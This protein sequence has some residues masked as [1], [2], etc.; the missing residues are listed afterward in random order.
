MGWELQRTLSPLGEVTAI[1]RDTVDFCAPDDL[2]RLLRDLKPRLIVNA[3]AYTAVDRAETE[4]EVAE[5]VNAA[6]PGVLAEEAVAL[7]A[8]LVHYSTDY[9][10]DGTKGTPYVED[11]P[12]HPLNVYGSTKLRGEVA[13]LAPGAPCVVLRTSWV[14]GTRGANFLLTMLR[15]AREREELKVVADQ[16]GSPTWCRSLAEVTALLLARGGDDPVGYLRERSGVYH[17]T[18]GGQTSWHGFTQRILELD[19]DR[20]TQKVKR[21]LPVT[22]QEFGSK[23]DR[24]LYSVL[25]SAKLERTFGVRLPDWSKALELALAR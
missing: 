4:P 20:E 23:T 5:A 18:Q 17:A 8:A 13:A 3:A 2:R 14:Y 21:V 15:L 24:P 9:V 7:G 22:T 25:D 16:V 12:T 1:D 6:T 11:D 10:F 19:P